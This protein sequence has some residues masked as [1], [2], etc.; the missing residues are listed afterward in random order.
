MDKTAK[1]EIF[2][3]LLLMHG[4]DPEPDLS[5]ST[6]VF[7]VWDSQVIATIGAWGFNEDDSI[8]LSCDYCNWLTGRG[9]MYTT[10]G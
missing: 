4:G 2:L 8:D 10:G 5:F 7:N 3:A 1:E 9:L 6:P